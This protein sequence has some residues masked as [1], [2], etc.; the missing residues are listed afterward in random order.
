MHAA[1][2]KDGFVLDQVAGGRDGVERP[3]PFAAGHDIHEGLDQ[4]LL[5][6]GRGDR[7]L[8][9]GGCPD[10]Q[11]TSGHHTNQQATNHK[12]P[13]LMRDR[14]APG[15][16][17]IAL[18]D[19]ARHRQ[20]CPVGRLRVLAVTV[21]AAIVRHRLYDIDRVINRTLVYGLLTLLLA[22]VY[23]G[24]VFV[25]G[26]LLAPG[27]G[28]SELAI[29]AS[30][31]AVAALFQPA[32]RWVQSIVDRRFNRARY[33]AARTIA[34]FST[35]LRDEIDLNTLSTELLRVVDQTVQ[36]TQASL[37]LRPASVKP[38]SHPP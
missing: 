23:T 38:P 7:R 3:A 33:D 8:G 19:Q 29:A 6:V 25:L 4:V 18:A 37:W 31:L 13:P 28:Q 21:A 32:R 30:T 14:F 36:P 9:E 16:S 10:Q 15:R 24:G 22:T 27:D 34:A 5:H 2:I 1:V 20:F 12:I 11:Q 26:R 17:V 35:R